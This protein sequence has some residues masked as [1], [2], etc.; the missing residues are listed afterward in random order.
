VDRFG[1]KVGSL[2]AGVDENSWTSSG[3]LLLLLSLLARA[4]PT[5][6]A[7]VLSVGKGNVP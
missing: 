5:E 6:M 1:F 4:P 2:P 3:L 7:S